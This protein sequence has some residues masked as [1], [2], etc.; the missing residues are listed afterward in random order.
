MLRN[1]DNRMQR[2]DEEILNAIVSLEGDTRWER[3]H[4]WFLG[5][6]VHGMKEL[7]SNTVFNSGRV[8]ELWDLNHKI[9]TAKKELD[10]IR[11]K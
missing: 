7:G 1:R 3:V 2:P 9:T 6:L 11:K 4:Q 10:V 8:A 5:S